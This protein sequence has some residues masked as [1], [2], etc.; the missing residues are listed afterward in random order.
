MCRL[1]RHARELSKP[2]G[3]V[4]LLALRVIPPRTPTT[5]Y[6]WSLNE[7]RIGLSNYQVYCGLPG[8][9]D[10]RLLSISDRLGRVV[11]PPADGLLKLLT[12]REGTLIL[13]KLP[14]VPGV[15]PQLAGEIHNCDPR[16]EAEGF[17]SGM[18]EELVDVK[19]RRTIF[20]LRIHAKLKSRDQDRV[21]QAAAMLEEMQRLP[22]ISQ[23]SQRIA[24]ERSKLISN[25]PIVQRK[26]DKLLKDFEDDLEMFF[27][28]RGVELVD[29]EVREAREYE[30]SEGNKPE[31]K[32]DTKSEE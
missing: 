14:M 19:L 27:D 30:A 22:S 11:V 15:E 12:V 9:K 24:Q 16:V 10:P 21:D 4:E 20:M 3:R 32:P 13:A 8:E 17:I 31:A 28:P 6:L 29:K 23:F 7:P 5:L 18:R 1:Q 26:I 25:E 2:R